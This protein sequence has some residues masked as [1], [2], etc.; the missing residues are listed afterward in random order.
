MTIPKGPKGKAPDP[1]LDAPVGAAPP[2]Q[3]VA[4]EGPMV[5]INDPLKGAILSERY[6]LI[7]RLNGGGMGEVYRAEDMKLGKNVAVKILPQA[8]TTSKDIVSRFI[9]E[10]KT[11]PKI[12]HPNIVDVTDYD[13]TKDGV[14]YYVMQHLK[15]MDLNDLLAK[16][17][18]LPWKRAV[19][20]ILQ[21]G[22]ALSAAHGYK[23]PET[24]APEPIIHRDIK[25]ANIFLIE[26]GDNPD[27]V[28]L[29]DFGVAKLHQ[30]S[31]KAKR[32]R[33]AT[34]ALMVLGTPAYMS[35][36]QTKG[37]NVD[38]RTDIY[39]VAVILY[40]AVCGAPPF[41]DESVLRMMEMH[42]EEMVVPPSKRVAGIAIPEKLESII[43]KGLSKMPENRFQDMGEMMGALEAMVADEDR[44][45]AESEALKKPAPEPAKAALAI[46]EKADASQEIHQLS[47]EAYN[48]MKARNRAKEAKLVRTRLVAAGVIAILAAGGFAAGHYAPIHEKNQ[49][50]VSQSKGAVDA[51]SQATVDGEAQPG[52]PGKGDD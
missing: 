1:T 12:D 10:A 29:L 14:V 3:A 32:E 38:A 33:P 19:G 44:K 46:V 52:D 37:S 8:L 31:E 11:T 49:A 22:K 7:E 24:G 28:K 45:L 16:E 36:E 27:F 48:I 51:G 34:H 42:R 2:R 47:S 18:N 4:A 50:K 15:G 9:Q 40:E 41:F 30:E 26:L 25:P 5:I 43:M 6:K 35:P 13:V 23:N 20:I 39:A 17:S 21:V